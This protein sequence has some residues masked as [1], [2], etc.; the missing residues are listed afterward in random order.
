[1]TVLLVLAGGA[2]G[3]PARYLTDR[4]VSARHDSVFPWGTFAVN[5]AA[6][7][8]LGVLVEAAPGWLLTL[9]GVGFCGALSTYSTFG[10]E[11]V[12]LAQAGSWLL[13]SANVTASLAGGV[14]AAVAGMGVGHALA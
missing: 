8:L 7:V 4:F 14:A 5:M 9:G 3:A 6:C 11:T 12:R 13:A 10:Y 1:M 2:I